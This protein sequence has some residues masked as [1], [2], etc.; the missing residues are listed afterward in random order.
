MDAHDKEWFKKPLPVGVQILILGVQIKYKLMLNI[1]DKKDRIRFGGGAGVT[2][3]QQKN[4]EKTTSG[5]CTNS[6]FGC[7]N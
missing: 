5:W 4:E 6:N 7:T 3:P 1:G 2:S